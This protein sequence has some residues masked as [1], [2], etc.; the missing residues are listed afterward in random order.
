MS[1][2]GDK[3]EPEL[4][5]I[6]SNS[7][8][9]NEGTK[10]GRI[11][12]YVCGGNGGNWSLY[13]KENEAEK[14]P[15]FPFL[16]SI[17][18]AEGAQ[19][20]RSNGRI[21]AC[22]LCFSFLIQQWHSYEEND[23]PISKRNYWLK[24]MGAVNNDTLTLNE[25]K[26]SDD[27][28]NTS[29][30]KSHEIIM[31]SSINS[32]S[33]NDAKSL[34]N[35]FPGLSGSDKSKHEINNKRSSDELSSTTQNE[36]KKKCEKLGKESK[37]SKSLQDGIE[38]IER[39]ES[40]CS[41]GQQ[42]GSIHLRTVHTKPQLKT[43]TPFYPF[44]TQR[45][46]KVDF[47]GKVKVCKSCKVYLCKQW[48]KY[49][50]SHTPLSERYYTLPSACDVRKEA[51]SD[52][53]V[54]FLC[55][56]DD[57]KTSGRD[58]RATKGNSGVP[59]F[60]FLLR[61]SPPAGVTDVTEAGVLKVCETCQTSLTNQW[62]AFEDAGL[63]IHEREYKVKKGHASKNK[64]DVDPDVLPTMYTCSVCKKQKTR[65]QIDYSC[66]KEESAILSG[67][68]SVDD[69]GRSP[70]CFDCK[71]SDE[72]HT[73]PS[74]HVSHVKPIESSRKL[75]SDDTL[76]TRMLLVKNDLSPTGHG[77]LANS[78]KLNESLHFETCFLCGERVNA[79]N[80]EY[81]YVFP[82]QYA[83]G[84]KPFFP[85]LAYR[86]PAYHA[87]P[88]SPSGTVITCTYCH[89]NMIN[90]WYEC[91]KHKQ[92]GISNPWVRQYVFSEF[93]CYL[94]SK[95][96]PRHKVTTVS[97]SDFPFLTKVRK[98]AR[99]F[100]MNNQKDYVVC[101]HCKEIIHIQ[102]ENFDKCKVDVSEREY[103]LPMVQFDSKVSL[104]LIFF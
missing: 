55:G 6:S 76:T 94:C 74:N 77:V 61:R 26:F 51:N 56:E 90:Q 89:G 80:L 98:P 11:L 103:E 28:S 34:E 5:A 104:N 29:A 64:N 24:R 99:G 100:R 39:G 97:S 63:G 72:Q 4:K 44:L 60:P 81:L 45:S 18:M 1:S 12:C 48:E 54:C 17:D 52:L 36:Q 40:C 37:N 25:D 75:H 57:P 84:Y 35:N 88:P 49:E 30:G 101:Q 14:S 58:V 69:P 8:D 33:A 70:V 73:E 7:E 66:G 13:C 82:R 2:K 43:E 22:T 9:K 83:K 23:T 65:G 91:E 20:M 53:F 102:E 95:I 10:N 71:K 78:Q 62:N 38:D 19:P 15:Y 41:C 42:G 31:E 93:T 50:K 67:N 27:E 86:V 3:I 87:K 85:S 79:L 16:Q 47:M 68:R 96:F 92:C 21:D 32:E 59:Y 46:H